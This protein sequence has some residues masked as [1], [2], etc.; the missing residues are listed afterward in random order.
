MAV[1]AGNPLFVAL[2]QAREVVDS[3]AAF[4]FPAPLLDLGHKIR[5]G[6]FKVDE[7]V[8]LADQ[9]H[10]QVEEVRV[11]LEIPCAHKA[12]VVKVRGEDAGVLV[13]CP[14]LDDD[15]AAP[16]DVHDILEPLVQEINLKIERPTLHVGVE[17][18]KIRVEVN[19][20][21]LGRPAVM[22][23]QHLCQGGLAAAYV[24]CYR[25]VHILDVYFIPS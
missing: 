14:V 21:E 24:A 25:N 22:G 17:I 13:D 4:I 6:G 18:G 15:I 2:V 19:R 7:Q 10:H 9:R 5:D 1:V 23:R 12:H 16:G 8:G 11:V 20:F 3:D